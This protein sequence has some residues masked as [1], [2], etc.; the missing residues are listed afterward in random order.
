MWFELWKLNKKPQN[1]AM[2]VSDVD[3]SWF[4][5]PSQR[6]LATFRKCYPYLPGMNG[7]IY[8]YD[9]RQIQLKQN[10]VLGTSMPVFIVIATKFQK[11][12]FSVLEVCMSG[13]KMC[14]IQ[15]ADDVVDAILT[16]QKAVIISLK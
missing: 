1:Q 2:M 10:D 16:V 13:D 9:K 11:L 5:L 6:M 14:R 12:P 15:K 4:S 7:K 3:I 8:T